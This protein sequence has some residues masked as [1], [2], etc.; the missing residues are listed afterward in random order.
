MAPNSAFFTLG[1]YNGSK[2]GALNF[3]LRET[4]PDA[5]IIGVIDSDYIVAPDWL[6]AMVPV[7]ADPKV[8][9][10]QSPQDYPDADDRLFKRLMFWEFVTRSERNAP[11]H[12]TM[13]LIR[14]QALLDVQ[15]WAEWCIAEDAEL[16]LRLFRAGYEVVYARKSFGKG[17]MPDDFAAFRQQR[18]AGPMAPC[19]SCAPM[20]APC[21][22]RSTG[23]LR[24][25]SAGIS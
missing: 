17:V 20:P 1:K 24:S 3:A 21:S 11:I 12:R 14:K 25:A 7:F 4:A 13:T 10:T 5:E 22:T 19:A 9:F 6:R 23:S 18:S 15:G 16:G 2:A 8:G